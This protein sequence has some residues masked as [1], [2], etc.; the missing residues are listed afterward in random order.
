M[1]K[2]LKI[3]VSINSTVVKQTPHLP[4]VK[5]LSQANVA[6][7]GRYNMAKKCLEILVSSNSTVAVNLPQH[8]KV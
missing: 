4:E 2:V 1:Q 8:P 3:L 7:T 5:G 6:G